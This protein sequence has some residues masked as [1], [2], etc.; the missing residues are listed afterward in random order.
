MAAFPA[1]AAKTSIPRLYILCAVVFL[2]VIGFLT[3]AVYSYHALT[4]PA[5]VG[6]WEADM[7]GDDGQDSTTGGFVFNA[8]GTG[9]AMAR[10]RTGSAETGLFSGMGMNIP[11][12][13]RQ[14]GPYLVIQTSTFG[15]GT[16]RH[17]WQVNG[18]TLTIF[19]EKG[20]HVSYYR[21]K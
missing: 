3:I 8:D 7:K 16:N 12:K 5:F 15:L 11:I 18:D 17:R 20:G 10:N 1:P 4:I 13:W 2:A 6:R 21:I 19:Y 14:E 9:E